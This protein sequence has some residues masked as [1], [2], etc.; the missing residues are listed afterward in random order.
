MTNTPKI[1]GF[2]AAERHAYTN[3]DRLRTMLAGSGLD[4]VM[5]VSPENVPYLSGFYNFDI[6]VIPERII[7]VIW[8]VDGEPVFVAQGRRA[9]SVGP[10]D[11][12]IEDRRGYER[13][14]VSG[15]AVVVEALRDRGL[16]SA[17][18]GFE[19][20]HF[21]AGYL[22]AIRAALP[23]ARFEDCFDLLEEVR[24]VKTPAEIA[25]LRRAGQ[26]TSRAIRDA[27][28]AARPGDSEKSVIDRM[29]YLVQQYG[30]DIVAFNVFGVGPKSAGG[31][32]LAGDRPI[33]PGDIMRCDFGGL[34]DGYYSDLARTAV[35][36]KPTE[37]QLDIYRK[38]VE[39]EHAMV[40]AMRPGVPTS[41]LYDVGKAA[42]ERLG[43]D[44]RWGILGHGLGL[45][46]HE[47][48]HFYPWES[49]ELEPGMV[50]AVEPGFTQ[51]GVDGYHV[52]DLI[53]VTDTGAEWLTD[54]ADGRDLF[55]IE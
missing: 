18:I 41:H 40:D 9:R 27:Y 3:L 6:R 35:V 11:T 32:V 34:F 52:E 10:A 54:P 23:A 2:E 17:R 5:A 26:A 47:R 44:F 28:A 16:A 13:E 15:M 7:V 1:A 38:L 29:S 8:P 33:A 37:R 4:A 25:T 50:F 12:F 19:G 14:D 22:D 48:P 20:R 45:G 42:Y 31:H 21:P 55:V 53:L 51:P 24:M 43:L 49:R 39:I 46:I 36:G 30:A